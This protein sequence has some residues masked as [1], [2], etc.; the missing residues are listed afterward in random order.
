MFAS[1]P[2][3]LFQKPSCPRGCYDQN[4][5][6]CEYKQLWRIIA[7]GNFAIFTQLLNHSSASKTIL[8]LRLLLSQTQLYEYNYSR[9][10]LAKR[11]L[12][13]FHSA[14]ATV[15][16]LSLSEEVTPERRIFVFFCISICLCILLCIFA[17]VF[18]FVFVFVL[19]EEDAKDDGATCKQ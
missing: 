15:S 3:P 9:R 18:V 1:Q 5:H 13:Y 8:P 7:K 12:C 11:Q 2:I 19:K 10:N 17:C 14:P 16:K 6:K 4:L